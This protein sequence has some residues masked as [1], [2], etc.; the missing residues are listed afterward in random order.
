MRERIAIREVGLRDG[1]QNIAFNVP[2][3]HKTAWI[4]LEH[5]AGVREMEVTSLVP[6]KLLPQFAD[7]E[8]VA[9]HA[10]GLDGLTVS[11]LIPNVKGAERGI[12]LGL[13]ELN[14]VLSAS[15]S[16]NQANVRRST[17]QS[18]DDFKRILEIRNGTQADKRTRIVGGIA[19]AFGCSIEGPVSEK[20]VLE[21][22][23]ELL[24]AG[25]DGLIVA[26]TVGY[27]NPAAVRRIFG[28]VL[29]ETGKTP[30]TA[31]FHDTRGLGI[32]NVL[33]GLDVGV[34]RFDA[35]LGGLGGCP[36]APGASGNIVLEDTV[37]MAE[38]MGLDTG[39]DLPRLF[40]VRHTVQ[41]YLPGVTLLGGT[42]KAGLPRAAAA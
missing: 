40:E 16:H 27:G 13:H 4:S 29:K 11:A 21:I 17:R 42:A 6:P 37:F 19:T 36:Y 8:A 24:Q 31:H 10:L 22:A 26:D 34:R 35:S 5:A 3:E 18:I 41:S 2:T 30:V 23:V 25:A 9:R 32:A 20:R 12:A 38:S 28:A 15:E 7:S 1:L 33:A 39:I 14:Y